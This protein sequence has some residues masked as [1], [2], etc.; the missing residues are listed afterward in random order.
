MK[1]ALKIFLALILTFFILVI[2]FVT[3]I[4]ISTINIKLDESKLINLN[5][6]VAYYDVDGEIL[7]EESNGKR[8]SEISN[9]PEYTKNAF[10]AIEDKRF[11]SHHG[12]DYKGLGRALINNIK[13]ASFKE[14]ASTITQQLIKNTHLS[15]EKTIR[16]KIAEIK[17]ALQLEKRYTKEEI[18]EKYL[19]TIYFG[20]GCYGIF[21]AADYYFDKTPDK[22]D[23][24]E[25]A[26]LA[27]I[28][29]APSNYS[30]FTNYSKCNER[31]N[32]VLTEMFAQGYITEKEYADNKNTDIILT[33]NVKNNVEHDFLTMARREFNS[34][35]EKSPYSSSN[36]KVYT[37]FNPKLQKTIEGKIA[38]E[39]TVCD[40][41][42]VIVGSD[43][44]VNAYYSTCGN[45]RRQ[46][47]SVI[48]PL[49]VYAPA[50]E[51]DVVSSATCLLDEKTDFNGYSPSNYNDKY[52]GYVSV[53]ESLAKSLNVCAVKLLN[54]VGTEKALSYIKKTQIPVSDNDGSLCLALGVTEL[55]ATLTEITNA[56]NIFSNNGYYTDYSFI[57]KIIS[58]SGEILYSRND[59]KTQIFN[60]DT[61]TIMNDM[62]SY[63]VAEGTAKKLKFCP[64]ALYAKTGTVGSKKG[65]T[66]AYTVSYNSQYAL[67]V[68][69]GDK[70][71]SLMDNSITGGSL[72]AQV[73]AEIWNELH[74]SFPLAKA[75]INSDNVKEI[76]VDKISYD[77]E[78][79][80]VLA[81]EISPERYKTKFMFKKSAIP[82]EQSTRFSSPTVEAP[83]FTVNNNIIEIDLCLTEYVDALIYKSIDNDKKLVYDTKI[84]GKNTFTDSDI[85]PGAYY[86]YSVVPYYQSDKKTYLGKEILLGKL[87]TPK[88]SFGDDWW[89]NDLD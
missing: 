34:L 40:K 77:E 86:R 21:S 74:D 3:Y 31:K 47:G 1:K 58:E 27:G 49:L 62:L 7:A 22:L 68:W 35:I 30:P 67:G 45:I 48:K 19:N 12:I 41:S 24:N 60:D 25:S 87:K 9:I 81:D 23:I 89:I 46:L 63:T 84:S 76:Y 83:K 51:N 73:S 37:S 39:Q 26:M 59:N 64:L 38:E 29:K 8:V 56:Y 6:T 32:V 44:R 70:N 33:E 53:K 18:L 85:I 66:D 43:G 14:G 5:R 15:N 69:F 36:L 79:V 13:N 75:L 65:N 88:Q 78:H 28:I 71:N 55:G 50:I 54:Y 16:R 4:N 82:K 2:G 42:A 10:V 17:L 20:N 11:Y 80:L 52:Y 72:P 57:D 61:I